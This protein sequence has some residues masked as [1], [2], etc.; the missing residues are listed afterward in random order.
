[1]PRTVEVALY[2]FDELS[3]KAKEVA[4]EW[5]RTASQHD[6]WWDSVFDDAETIARLM[7]IE[8]DRKRGGSAPAIWFSGFSSQGDGACFEGRYAYAKGG[9]AKL[10]QYA[11]EDVT[12]H[13]IVDQLQALQKAHGYQLLATVK[14]R[15]H[16][17]HSGC[18]DIDVMRS[19]DADVSADTEQALARLLRDFMDWIYRQLNDEYDA[20]NS[21]ETVDDNIR[22][23]EY[24]F[25]ADGRR[26]RHD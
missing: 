13:A 4:R 24:E 21:N 2:Q 10:R 22:C 9:A 14:Q 12:L 7:G 20:L 25:E 1:M 18:T 26:T 16:Y 6:E 11:P 23:N 3:D 5:F 8:F 19:N 17:S 15:G